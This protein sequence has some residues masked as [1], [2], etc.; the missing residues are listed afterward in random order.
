MSLRPKTTFVL[1]YHLAKSKIFLA[2]QREYPSKKYRKACLPAPCTY[3]CRLHVSLLP[4]RIAAVYMY[5]CTL[6]LSLPTHPCH[7]LPIRPGVD[8]HIQNILDRLLG[9]HTI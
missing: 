6:H 1:A 8:E 3:R 4:T 9:L 2:I 7:Q 5:H